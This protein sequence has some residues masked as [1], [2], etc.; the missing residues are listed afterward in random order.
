MYYLISQESNAPYRHA[1]AAKSEFGKKSPDE[2]LDECCEEVIQEGGIPNLFDAIL[3]DEAQDFEENFYK[4]CYAAL[5][6]DDRRLIWA[7]DEAQS[8]TSLNAP[9]P[10]NIFGTDENDDPVVDLSGSY[11]RGIQKSQIMRKSYRAPKEIL[12]TAHVFG[13]GLK[14]DP[15]VQAITDKEGWRNIGY[16][17]EGDFRKYGEEIRLERPEENS[18]H[19]MQDVEEAD[20][21][22]E[23]KDFDTKTQEVEWVA[24]KIEEDIEKE[25]LAPEQIMVILLGGKKKGHGYMLR[26]ELENKSI[27]LN[28]VWE[29][30]RGVFSKDGEVTVS[31][32][33]RAK[34]NESSMV[35]VM[36]LE[37]VENDDRYVDTVKRRNEA[38]VG[39]TRARGWCTITGNKNDGAPFKEIKQVLNEVRNPDQPVTFPA[40]KPDNLGNVLE[41]ES[42]ETLED[43]T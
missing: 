18:P 15:P 29:G 16:E 33:D 32:I 35:Y 19:P 1:D 39:I 21:F 43:Y 9:S 20:P 6:T 13:M 24:K 25:E 41:S 37:E 3:V 8:L 5:T 38:F 31:G 26:E 34:G 11:E 30:D 2:L 14:R 12:M 42:Q 10:T 40:P 28:C 7:Y 4:M 22:I 27:S 23:F 17:V 36:G